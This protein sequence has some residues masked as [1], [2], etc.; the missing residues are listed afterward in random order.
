[1]SPTQTFAL[2]I[3]FPAYRSPYCYSDTVDRTRVGIASGRDSVREPQPQQHI[4][5]NV[6]AMG[7]GGL[8]DAV[9][10]AAQPW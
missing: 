10:A 2:L 5:S 6:P 3:L 1:M 7:P 9:N 4:A 8:C